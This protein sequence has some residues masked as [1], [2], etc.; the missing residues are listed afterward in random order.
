VAA[1]DNNA[2][3]AAQQQALGAE[4]RAILGANA[5]PATLGAADRL[6]ADSPAFFQAADSSQ[7]NVRIIVTDVDALIAVGGGAAP[8]AY[9]IQIP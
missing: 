1:F 3:N 2:P 9:K 4:F 6:V 8:N 7:A 5:L